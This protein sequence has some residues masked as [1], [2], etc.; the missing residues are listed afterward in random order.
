MS[1][2]HSTRRGDIRSQWVACIFLLTS[3]TLS[4]T[5]SAGKIKLRKLP[6]RLDKHGL[7]VM[8]LGPHALWQ[9]AELEFVNGKDFRAHE[10]FFVAALAPGTYTIESVQTQAGWDSLKSAYVLDILDLGRKFEIQAGKVTHLGMT[11]F[12]A[13]PKNGY[14]N[15]KRRYVPLV[16]KASGSERSY[17]QEYYPKLAASIDPSDVILSPYEYS[18]A[19]LSSVRELLVSLYAKRAYEAM[20]SDY[21]LRG[22]QS[23]KPIEITKSNFVIGDLGIV[24]RVGSNGQFEYLETGTVSRIAE[25]EFASATPWFY[26]RTGMIYGW[27]KDQVSPVTSLP[28]DFLATNGAMID[29]KKVVLTDR[30]FNILTTSD[31][32]QSWSR[33]NKQSSRENQSVSSQFTLGASRLFVM[34]DSTAAV[35]DRESTNVSELVLPKKIRKG[36]QG[37][38]ETDAG[39]FVHSQVGLKPT[40]LHFLAD[41]A[42]EWI[43]NTTEN[44]FGCSIHFPDTHGPDVRAICGNSKYPTYLRSQDYGKTWHRYQPAVANERE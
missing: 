31:S 32:G 12:L 25:L 2:Q 37:V 3:L 33:Y 23:S 16:F 24:A 19:K 20:Q 6:D 18:D 34:A 17:L 9:S 22:M 11:Y 36:I 21:G 38:Y 7:V 27:D 29:D 39:L 5:A 14:G 4:T 8:Q 15:E 43:S 35:V 44:Y 26:S 28:R 30:R 41:G 42:D 1:N 40:K 10:G 13:D